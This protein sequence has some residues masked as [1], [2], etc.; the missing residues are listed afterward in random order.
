MKYLFA[1]S[2]MFFIWVM[3]DFIFVGQIKTG[4]F[5][6]LIGASSTTIIFKTLGWLK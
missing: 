2:A 6:L 5:T 1:L 3:L 4:T